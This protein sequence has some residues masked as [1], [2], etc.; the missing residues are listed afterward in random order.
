[1]EFSGLRQTDR[2]AMRRL[3][4]GTAAS[5]L[6]LASQGVS[7]A[8]MRSTI[9]MVDVS[10]RLQ[11]EKPEDGT[12]SVGDLVTVISGADGVLTPDSDGE[13]RVK[14][15]RDGLLI[16]EPSEAADYKPL[17]GSTVL[18]KSEASEVA[19][20]EPDT[21]IVPASDPAP[22]APQAEDQTEDQAEEK[23]GDPTVDDAPLEAADN[24]PAAPV[25]TEEAEAPKTEP[26]Q[27]TAIEKTGAPETSVPE[28]D[29]PETGGSE[30]GV[31]DKDADAGADIVKMEGPVKVDPAPETDC[32][33]LAA[34][35]YDP[36]AVAPGVDYADLDADAIIAACLDAIRTYPHGARFYGQITRGYHKAGLLG[37]ALD[38]TRQGAALDSPHSMANL[39]AMFAQGKAVPK[40]DEKALEW[41][42]R[43][44]EAGSPAGMVFAA[45]MYRDGVGT[46][47]NYTRAAELYA[48][49]VE[50][51]IAEAMTELAVF[52]DRGQGVSKDPEKAAGL[53]L[54]ALRA[55]DREAQK[56]LFEAPGA[57]TREAREAIQTT[58]K[59]NGFYRGAIDAD[60]G[61]G[62]RNALVRYRRAK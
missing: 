62:T 52:Y 38:A 24:A 54:A 41:Y 47:R 32:D 33:M 35:P 14:S 40:S 21:D 10:G 12:P 58:L 16:A 49:A 11:L 39:G 45:A 28:T 27:A 60:F 23:S 17:V 2:G 9:T 48:M 43:A 36:D 15:I 30:T 34:H 46:T 55:E 13:W 57:I 26:A 37:K 59:A 20:T 42:E 31:Q 61:T 3:L 18:I 53:L 8:Q 1:M 22:V 19:Q 6:L 7:A 44:A 51:D 5:L 56:L 50:M 29:G 4:A 25:V